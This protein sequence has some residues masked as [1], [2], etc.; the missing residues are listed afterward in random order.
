MEHESTNPSGST[1]TVDDLSAGPRGRPADEAL[2]DQYA[3]DGPRFAVWEPSPPAP[4]SDFSLTDGIWSRSEDTAQGE[5]VVMCT[6]SLLYDRPL[7]RSA[8]VGDTYE[9]RSLFSRVRDCLTAADLTVGSLGAVVADMY[10]AMSTIPPRYI[11]GHYTNAPPEYLD[12]L[13][14]AGFDCMALANPYN[15]DAGV[16]GISS[17]E[18]EVHGADMVPSGLGRVKNPV[19]EVNGIRIAVLS[20]T[21][22]AYRADEWITPDGASRL[23]NVDSEENVRAA[24]AQVKES[25]AQFVLAYLDCRSTEDSMDLAARKSAAVRL[26]EAGADYVVCTRPPLVSRQMVHSTSDG[27]TVPIASGTG[28]FM[29]GPRNHIDSPAAILKLVVRLTEDRRIEV[30]DSYVPV[31]RFPLYRGIASPVVPAHPYYNPDY[32]PADFADAEKTVSQRLGSHI[33]VDRTRT[34][35]IDSH[36]RP[37]ITPAE[38]AETLGLRFS[39]S[40]K[41]ILG[42]RIDV[43]VH[44]VAVQKEHLHEGCAA[45][46]ATRTVA[47]IVPDPITAEDAESAGAALAIAKA[48]V[49]SVPT[50]VVDDPGAAFVKVAAAIRRRYSPLTVA[51]TG[52]AGKTTAMEMLAPALNQRLRTLTVKG[53][54]NTPRGAARMIQKLSDDDQ[55]YIQEVHGGS[56]GTA[57]VASRMLAPDIA[58]VTSIGDAHLRQLGTIEKVIEAKMQIIDGLSSDGTLILNDDNEYLHAQSLPV[59]TLRYSTSDPSSDFV[60]QNIRQRDDV[61]EFEVVHPDGITSVVVHSRGMHNVSNALGA[62]AVAHTAGVPTHTIVAGLSRYRTR[63]VRQN[64]VEAGGYRLFVDAYNSN[65]LSLRSSISTLCEIPVGEGARRIAVLGDMGEQGSKAVENHIAAGAHISETAVDLVL[66]QGEGMAHTA[67]AIRAGGGSVSH[68]ETV[69]ELIT[70]VRDHVRPGDLILFKAAGSV[71]L[72]KKVV[73]PV[74]GKVV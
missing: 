6:G 21:V 20:F 54:Y 41:R 17:T 58:L 39:R 34:V 53:N 72:V 37:Q 32:R 45:V 51:V 28:S 33:G 31:R 36:I 38:I 56:P 29:A 27:R 74:F 2:V 42:E 60:A 16:R 62:F 66:S 15:L 26:A 46:L 40:D 5:A 11:D 48:P 22:N 65:P 9:F 13:R 44:V 23:L 47:G 49:P 25:G 12:A 70:A 61:V 30:E 64:L 67:E 43:P 4:R 55:A 24:V 69:D 73:Y 68:A 71:D 8:R 7:E 35:T 59:R 63:S 57:S 3:A 18:R 10:P 52:S 14:Y 1:V 19:F 50:L